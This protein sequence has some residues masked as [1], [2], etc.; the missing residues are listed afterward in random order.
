M[1]RYKKK[2][3]YLKNDDGSLITTNEELTKKWRYYIDNLLICEKTDDV[4]S[5]DLEIGEE[6]KCVEPSLE[7][8]RFQVNALINHKIT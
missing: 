3:R 6:Q 7:E 1:R 8:I 5:F 4:Y 2:E